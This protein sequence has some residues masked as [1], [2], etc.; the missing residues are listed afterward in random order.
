MNEDKNENKKDANRKK[1]KSWWEPALILF[2]KLSLW[3]VIPVLIGVMI[4]KWLDKAFHTEPW[5]FLASV[6][7]AFI[8]SMFRLVK[9]AE[10]EY[11]KIDE[12]EK[13]G[14]KK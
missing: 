1:T 8:F 13:K 3:I 7:I 10:D 12:E 9:D 14:K 6:G 4:G 2:S 5:L 11:K